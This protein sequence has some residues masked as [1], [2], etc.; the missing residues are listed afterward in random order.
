[1]ASLNAATQQQIG[2]V[3]LVLFTTENIRAERIEYAK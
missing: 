3:H 1:M 2:R